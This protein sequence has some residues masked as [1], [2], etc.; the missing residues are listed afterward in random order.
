MLIIADAPIAYVRAS[1]ALMA[2]LKTPVKRPE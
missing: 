2:L 1:S